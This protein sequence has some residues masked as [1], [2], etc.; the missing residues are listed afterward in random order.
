MTVTEPIKQ[1][2]AIVGNETKLVDACEV[3]QNAIWQAKGRG[4]AHQLLAEII[5][6][7]DGQYQIGLCDDADGRFPSRRF[8]ED[9]AATEAHL[10]RWVG[11]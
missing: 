4:R 7:K 2:A 6:R 1:A 3:S 9:V 10:P 8:A 5:Q 11:Q